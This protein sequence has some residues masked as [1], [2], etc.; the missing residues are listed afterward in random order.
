MT[1][2]KCTDET[3]VNNIEIIVN[4]VNQMAKNVDGKGQ[5]E[6]NSA[7]AVGMSRSAFICLLNGNFS[8]SS[9]YHQR[10][11]FAFIHLV[12]RF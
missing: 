7:K 3:M 1:D 11:P 6:S 10:T 5:Q 9:H 4:G 12:T 8:L 2:D